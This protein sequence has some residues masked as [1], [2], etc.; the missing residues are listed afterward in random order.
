MRVPH[1]QWHETRTHLT[2]SLALTHSL[3]APHS[4]THCPHNKSICGEF[5]QPAWSLLHQL[6][7]IKMIVPIFSLPGY[8]HITWVHMP[9]KNREL[10][11]N[12]KKTKKKTLSSNDWGKT[13]LKHPGQES[14]KSK[15]RYCKKKTSAGIVHPF[16]HP[17]HSVP[18][19]LS[20]MS[21][22]HTTSQSVYSYVSGVWESKNVGASKPILKWSKTDD[23]TSSVGRRWFS[24]E[25]L[26]AEP[27]RA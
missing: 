17:Q 13:H 14:T 4:L 27:G 25:Q 10:Q 20:R 21:R 6:T 22:R 5:L 7:G 3:T 19:R 1:T 15:W 12:G 8:S 18:K 9:F 16:L 2:H 11:A 26:S 24:I 23:C